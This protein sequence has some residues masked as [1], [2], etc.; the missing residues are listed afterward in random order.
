MGNNKKKP[1]NDIAYQNKDIMSKILVEQ[2]KGKPLK[3]YGLN[4]P[5]IVNAEPTNLPAVEANELRLDNLFHLADGTY[6]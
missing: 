4:L 5:D 2:F 6:Q 3:V 1:V